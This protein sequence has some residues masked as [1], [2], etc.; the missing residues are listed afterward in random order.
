[1]ATT[2]E[3]GRLGEDI[4][5]LFLMKRGYSIVC[6]NYYRKWGEIDII[7][8][9][10]Q[11]LYFI[12]VKTVTDHNVI[13]ETSRGEYRPEDNIN[14]WKLKKLS[15]IISTYLAN[16]AVPDQEWKFLALIVKLNM[17]TRRAHV[18]IIED[19]VI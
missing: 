2:K 14:P 16:S 17:K 6:R 13:R 5:C 9:L 3:I 18:Y 10:G 15:R 12:E 7:A 1:M 8:E 19:I 11:I 4:A